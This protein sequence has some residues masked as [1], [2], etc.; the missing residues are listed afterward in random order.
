MTGGNITLAAN[1]DM[2]RQM[3]WV[4]AWRYLYLWNASGVWELRL[5]N[6]DGTA[7]TLI[8]ILPDSSPSYEFTY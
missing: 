4:D 6:V 7:S 3:R 2:V 1:P 8:D 5:G